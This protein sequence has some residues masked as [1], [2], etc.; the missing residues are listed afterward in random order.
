MLLLKKGKNREI[1]PALI[2]YFDPPLES[3]FN[4][5]RIKKAI[6]IQGI[7]PVGLQGIEPDYYYV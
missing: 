7:A 2:Q 3:S 6:Q 1:F 5:A 4:N